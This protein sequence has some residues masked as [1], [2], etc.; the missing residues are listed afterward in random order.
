[1]RCPHRPRPATLQTQSDSLQQ[2]IK[3]KTEL[4]SN[5]NAQIK[6]KKEIQ[7]IYKSKYSPSTL[8]D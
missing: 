3:S 8:P 5:P 2:N 1:M 4:D 6:K 7:R